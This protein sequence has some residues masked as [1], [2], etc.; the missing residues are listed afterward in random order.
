MTRSAPEAGYTFIEVLAVV[1]ILGVLAGVAVPNY[2]GAEEDE[3]AAARTAAINVALAL[4][5]SRHG[6][7]PTAGAGF[8]AFLNDRRYFPAEPGADRAGGDAAYFASR[9]NARLCRVIMP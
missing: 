1:L 7:C 4:Y 2:F 3:R 6:S 9:F 5:Q 8:T